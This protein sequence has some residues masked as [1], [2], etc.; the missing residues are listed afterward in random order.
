MNKTT[1]AGGVLAGGQARRMGGND[2]GLITLAGEHLIGHVVRRFAPQVGESRLHLAR[3]RKRP[4]SRDLAA[5]QC[6]RRRHTRSWEWP[7]ADHPGG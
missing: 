1:I 7:A 2:K 5:G 4:F 3:W 6:A